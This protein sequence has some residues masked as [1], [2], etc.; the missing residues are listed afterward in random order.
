MLPGQTGEN[1]AGR[2]TLKAVA[3]EATS[4]NNFF[5]PNQIDLF[6]SEGLTGNKQCKCST[7]QHK[8][9]HDSQ[10]VPLST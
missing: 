7:R 2:F 10:F 1:R 9:T 6:S 4:G 3:Q 5:S 8:T